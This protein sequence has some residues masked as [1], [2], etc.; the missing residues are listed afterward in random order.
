MLTELFERA[1]NDVQL[2]NTGHISGKLVPHRAHTSS[3]TNAAAWA[4]SE[5]PDRSGPRKSLPAC[6]E[7]RSPCPR[8]SFRALGQWHRAGCRT[9]LRPLPLDAVLNKLVHRPREKVRL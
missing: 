6:G 7:T 4:T 3:R 1:V 5:S 8:G 9:Q 2:P